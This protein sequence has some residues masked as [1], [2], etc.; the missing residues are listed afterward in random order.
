MTRQEHFFLLQ[1][2]QRFKFNS[3]CTQRVTRSSLALLA[4]LLMAQVFTA[5]AWISK[6]T[7]GKKPTST[8]TSSDENPSEKQAA[9]YL[10]T[11]ARGQQTYQLEKGNFASKIADL[12]IGSI[13]DTEDYDYKISLMDQTQVQVTA[14]AKRSGL[15][16][17]TASVFVVKLEQTGEE[18]TINL[19]CQT[20]NPSQMPPA[21]PPAPK[22]AGHSLPECLPG[23]SQPNLANLIGFSYSERFGNRLRVKT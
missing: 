6:T 19:V 4:C 12:G 23:S 20:D 9:V 18:T 1:R 7:D 17:Y 15:R 10:K 22:T 14:T 5:C 3:S 8:E 16:S 13:P 21:M 11:I 2:M